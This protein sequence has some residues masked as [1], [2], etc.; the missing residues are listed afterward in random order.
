MAGLRNASVNREQPLLLPAPFSLPPPPLARGPR[1]SAEGD[2]RPGEEVAAEER[3]LGGR[4]HLLRL[5]KHGGGIET[6]L[7]RDTS[8]GELVVLKVAD[9]K[10]LS[11][12]AHLRLEHEA[13]VLRRVRN[14]WLAPLID[15]GRDR[16][17]LYLVMPYVPGLTLEQRLARGR[18]SVR[19]ALT[20][21]CCLMSALQEVHDLGVIHRDLKPANLIVDEGTPLERATLIDFGLS[22]STRLDSSLRDQPVGTV[23]YVSPEQAGVLGLEA[24]ERADLYSA[25]VVLFECL[26][27]HPPFTGET[28]GEVLRQHVTARPPELRSLGLAV[29]RA[30]DEVVQRLLRKDPRD[31]YQSAAA[32]LADLNAITGALDRGEPE[33]LLV[34]GLHDRRR[35]LTEPAFVGRD[36]ELAAL[37]GALERC[38]HGE[39]SLVLLE[40]ES[41]GGKTR[42]LAEL[43]QGS[44]RQGA[45]VL[46]GQGLDQAA[47]RPFQVLAG[48]AAGLLG[49]AREGPSLGR[50]LRLFLGGQHGAAC[51]ALP[52][53]GEVLGAPSANGLGPETFGQARTLQALSALLDALGSA[54][55][56]A[57]VLLDDCQWADE[58]TLKLLRYWQRRPLT[59]PP[60]PFPGRSGGTGSAAATCCSWSPSAPRTCHRATRSAA[61]SPRCI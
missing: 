53:L 4:V 9:G 22:W 36:E 37:A 10:A 24:D 56:P 54:E 61:S 47:Q 23:R 18:L 49:A 44:A 31:R 50:N 21:G 27:G 3:L 25:G 35:T 6:F 11:S 38:R 5:L 16:E 58:L 48:V 39:G 45:W 57:L 52:E 34:I 17:Q 46:R 40:A 7:G 51:A 32:V 2:E 14:P 43:A 55:R 59:P 1:G 12:S 13:G 28:V 30:L 19:E 33:P 20:V 15:F 29:P 26:A 42:L 41:G 60:H 8:G